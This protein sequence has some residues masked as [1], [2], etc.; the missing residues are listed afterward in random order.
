MYED[1]ELLMLDQGTQIF[2]TLHYLS[3][4]IHSIKNP[5]GTQEN[6]ARMCR[7]L[8]EC[9]HRL[10]D[11]EIFLGHYH[12]KFHCFITDAT[13]TFCFYFVF[14]TKGTYWIDP[15]L[16]CSSDNI[17]VSCNFTS[18]GQT[19]LKPVAVSKVC[20]ADN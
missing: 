12:C 1:T 5:L 14:F 4:L 2:K 11:G 7:D 15:N 13:L 17:E 8:F 9:E 20:K 18:G 16:G 19:C 3:T 10:N 6:P